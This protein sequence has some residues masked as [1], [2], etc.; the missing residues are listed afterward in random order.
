MVAVSFNVDYGQVDVLAEKVFYN[1]LAERFGE[2]GLNLERE[3]FEDLFYSSPISKHDAGNI[4][5]SVNKGDLRN[6]PEHLEKIY[7]HPHDAYQDLKNMEESFYEEAA[8]RFEGLEDIDP[9]RFRNLLN[10][11][12]ADL[13]PGDAKFIYNTLEAGRGIVKE[14]LKLVYSKPEDALLDAQAGLDSQDSKH[15]VAQD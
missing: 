3:D 5:E 15:R 12:N 6:F 7:P 14:A 9:E 11:S 8:E 10:Q 13:K 2:I 1:H 4:Y